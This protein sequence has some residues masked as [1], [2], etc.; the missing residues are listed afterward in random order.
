MRL[1]GRDFAAGFVLDCAPLPSRRAA[2]RDRSAE[3]QRDMIA[4]VKAWFAVWAALLV[5]LPFDA[6]RPTI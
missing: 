1:D 3:R 6:P 5:G 2:H 4:G